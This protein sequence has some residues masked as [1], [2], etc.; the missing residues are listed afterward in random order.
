MGRP[1]FEPSEKQRQDVALWVEAKVSVQEM[2]RRLK[3]TPKTFRK[4]F[5]I[6]LGISPEGKNIPG[7]LPGERPLVPAYQPT[8][9]QREQALILAGAQLARVEIARKMGISVAILE[10][11]FAEELAQGPVKCKADILSAMFYAGKGGNV[12]A[13]KVFLVFN[14]QDPADGTQSNIQPAAQG[15]IGKKE[16]ANEA[17]KN[18][19]AGTPFDGMLN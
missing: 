15:L 2:A 12:A 3:L 17:A 9:E 14:G 16:A 18:A 11:H 6:E 1:S 8:A 10:E 13:A 5:V 4:H 7:E 19:E